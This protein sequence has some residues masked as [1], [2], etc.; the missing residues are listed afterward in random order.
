MEKKVVCPKCSEKFPMK[1][2]SCINNAL[3]PELKAEILKETIFDT[4]CE[5]CS[6]TSQ[7]LYQMLYHDPQKNYCITFTPKAGVADTLVSTEELEDTTKRRVKSLAE[8]KEKILVLDAKLNDVALEI[9]KVALCSML[10]K[11]N[12]G[13]RIKAYFCKIDGNDLEFAVIVTGDT[14]YSYHKVNI[15][16][17]NQSLEVLNITEFKEENIFL[18]VGPTLASELLEKYKLG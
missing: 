13:K 4:V 11:Q 17:Y 18:R 5:S 10:E 7:M 1:I 16:V 15:E 2:Y 12:Q 3:E 14:D 8:L 9:A 6:Y